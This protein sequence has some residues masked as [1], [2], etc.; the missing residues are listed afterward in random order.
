MYIKFPNILYRGEYTATRSPSTLPFHRLLF[1]HFSGLTFL[2]NPLMGERC[3]RWSNR[4]ISGFLFEKS[5]LRRF[6]LAP[7]TLFVHHHPVRL[8]TSPSCSYFSFPFSSTFYL[9]QI[10]A[11]HLFPIF[12]RLPFL[13]FSP[14]CLYTCRSAHDPDVSCLTNPRPS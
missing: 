1:S 12:F 7:Y 10:F 14:T 6:F 3:E 2:S 8:L 4:W 11:L 5:R 13:L 9:S